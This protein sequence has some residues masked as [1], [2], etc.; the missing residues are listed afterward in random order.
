MTR[1]NIISGKSKFLIIYFFSSNFHNPE[2][3]YI[4]ILELKILRKLN[5]K[6]KQIDQILCFC[7]A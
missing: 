5:I 7:V 2:I 4:N 6:F 3:K 1:W